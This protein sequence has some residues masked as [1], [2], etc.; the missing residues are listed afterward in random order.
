MSNDFK[1]IG[2]IFQDGFEGYTVQPSTSLWAA[3][4]HKLWL[5]SFVKFSVYSFNVYYA[6]GLLVAAIV[7]SVTVVRN[8]AAEQNTHQSK[9][10]YSIQLEMKI[11]A[12]IETKDNYYPQEYYSEIETRPQNDRPEPLIKIT[13]APV[14]PLVSRPIPE[15]FSTDNKGMMPGNLEE[16]DG[17]KTAIPA[18]KTNTGIPAGNKKAAEKSVAENLVST[19]NPDVL[20]KSSSKEK[21]NKVEVENT[22]ELVSEKDVID[23]IEIHEIMEN[24]GTVY[25]TVIF[26]DTLIYYD[27]VAI[28]KPKLKPQL[29]FSVDV[30][31]GP[32]TSTFKYAHDITGFEDTLNGF[33]SASSGYQAGVNINLHLKRFEI[34]TGLSYQQIEEDFAYDEQ[35][36]VNNPVEFWQNYPVAP[37]YEI[38][39]TDWVFVFNIADSSYVSAPVIHETWTAQYDSNLVQIPSWTTEIKNYDNLNK[40]TYLNIP[41]LVGYTFYDRDKV[42]L[43]AK[44]GGNLGIFIHA[45]GKGISWADRRSVI[46]LNES[47]LHFMKTNF[48]WIFGM[49]VNYRFNDRFNFI[50]EPWYRGSLNSMFESTHPVSAK[51]NSV[52]LNVGLRFHL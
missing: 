1:N 34:T 18:N 6:A 3:I 19:Q 11:P 36:S 25:D 28:H 17:E 40:Y 15:N 29:N 48:S 51:V 21:I 50:I 32:N 8:L 30:Y 44:A 5:Q 42:S 2:K 35:T 20:S 27:T 33:T 12:W 10:G 47:E 46:Q 26:Y 13:T 41:L 16:A 43:A 52:G 39:T 22:S 7:G 24:T 14:L 9:N 45:K 37:L 49:A 31:G 4:R 23:P 38:D